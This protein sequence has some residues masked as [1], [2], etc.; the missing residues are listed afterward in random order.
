[1]KYL[2]SYKS[3]KRTKINLSSKIVDTRNKFVAGKYMIFINY[4]YNWKIG[5]GGDVL[6]LGQIK[7]LQHV[8][9]IDRTYYNESI[10]TY[11]DVLIIDFVPE[12]EQHDYTLFRTVEM[13]VD[14]EHN[15]KQILF[16]SN[17][18]K[19]AHEKFNELKE[20]QPYCDWEMKQDARK[21]NL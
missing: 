10:K 11:V 17:S 12:I 15:F 13:D 5:Q 16:E 18:L 4:T 3:N 20:Q 21:Y 6:I 14:G 9:E 2:E 19:E 7:N 1:M 8:K